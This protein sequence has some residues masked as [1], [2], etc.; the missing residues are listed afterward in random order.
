MAS[1]ADPQSWS[2]LG[3]LPRLPGFRCLVGGRAAGRQ[4]DGGGGRGGRGGRRGRLPV[5]GPGVRGSG[6]DGPEMRRVI[7]GLR[8]GAEGC[9][10]SCA[11]GGRYI[12]T[13]H[14]SR[15]R[16]MIVSRAA[17]K[18]SPHANSFAGREPH[19]PTSPR[20][21]T[22]AERTEA[23]RLL[24]SLEMYASKPC[25]TQED[26]AARVSACMYIRVGRFSSPRA[27]AA[28]WRPER[29]YGCRCQ[30]THCHAAA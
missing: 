13:A 1:R 23:C 3:C 5:R 22:S 15:P 30:S 28:V 14:S 6:D 24:V 9:K 10:V 25:R 8:E 2:H 29:G 26:G 27:A 4:D 17:A 7:R 16:A 21:T 18:H 12:V 11:S 19:S 20:L